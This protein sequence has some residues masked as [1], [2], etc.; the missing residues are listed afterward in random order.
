MGPLRVVA[1]GEEVALPPIP[2]RVL[3]ALLLESDRTV[4]Y[5]RLIFSVWGDSPPETARNTLQAHI[6]GLRRRLPGLIDS[7]RE[8]YR[9]DLSESVNETASFEELST[10]AEAAF[11]AG[12]YATA[13]ETSRRA[14][15]LWRSEPYPELDTLLAR[16]EADRIAAVYDGLRITL[17]R[18]LIAAGRADE[19]ATGLRS[20]VVERPLHEP[21]WEQLMIAYYSSGRQADALSAYGEIRRLL[22]EELGVAPSSA[23]VDLEERIL[24]QDPQLAGDGRSTPNNLPAPA[25]SFVGRTVE[26]ERLENALKASRLATIVGGPGI[27]KTRLAVETGRRL[28]SHYPGG[29]WL[30]RLVEASVGSD[31]SAVIAAAARAPDDLESLTELA[32]ALAGR[33][34]LIILDNCEHVLGP[35]REF[36]GGAEGAMRV[37]ATSRTPLGVAGESVVRLGPLGAIDGSHGSPV[38]EALQLFL[39]RAAAFD[40]PEEQWDS[41]RLAEVCRR[42]GGIPL[43]LELMASWVASIGLSDAADRSLSPAPHDRI[44][45]TPHHGSLAEAIEWTFDLLD[46]DLRTS[47]E[48][49]SVFAG[50]FT[51]D[52]FRSVCAAALDRQEALG[53]LAALAEASLL[54]VEATSDGTRCY[55]MLEPLRDY[56]AQRRP[57]D[58]SIADR[59]AAWYSSRAGKVAALARGPEEGESFRAVDREIGDFR[60][61]MRYLLACGRHREMAE[62]AIALQRYWFA[63]YLGWEA[64]RWLAEA[65]AGDLGDKRVATLLS[66]GWA[67]YTV[68]SYVLSEAYYEEALE[69]VRNDAD[70]VAQARAIY[71]LARIHLPRRFRDGEALL[72]RAL[73]LFQKTSTPLEASECRLWLGLRAANRG[74][75]EEARQWLKA[76]ITELDGLGY[77]GL[78]SV[79]HRYLSLAA[80]HEGN[81]S[82]AR[83]HLADAERHARA[84]DD[85]RAIGGAAI[86]RAMVEGRW[87][88][89]AEAA[90][91]MLQALEPLPPRADIDHCLVMFGAFPALLRFDRLATAGRLLGHLDRIFAAYGWT[92][93][94]ERIPWVTDIRSRLGAAGVDTSAPKTQSAEIAKEV[95]E[96][97]LEIAR[98]TTRG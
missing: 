24:L 79:G 37:L 32:A 3:A 58:G 80:W 85:K 40:P 51:V 77:R 43:A 9:L 25:D 31:V 52:A 34:C 71:G 44:T 48:I 86:Q 19:A 61:A 36:L 84:T 82:G 50:A 27:G 11:E 45:A 38:D 13:I 72:H 57:T 15:A 7:S 68:A 98:Q 66:A 2:R 29:V 89:P 42:A 81:E 28:M 6:S 41:D 26:L 67:S 97:L 65:L 55:R 12:D 60:Q 88:N 16:A 17:A 83:S 46:T 5:D 4:S 96:V 95:V 90:A 91:A 64:Q 74:D 20:L 93:L 10:E 78:I 30:A 54:S 75:S 35:V 49:A 70:L 87:G 39:D 14:S 47:F 53:Q 59:H 18:A 62:I 23:L 1:E 56:A 63:R 69:L 73:D 8:G 94:E 22:A 33:P 92:T 21:F 76:A